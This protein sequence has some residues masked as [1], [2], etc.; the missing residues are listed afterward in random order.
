[1]HL[2]S[3]G[4]PSSSGRW[5]TDSAGLCEGFD[6]INVPAP[7]KMEKITPIRRVHRQGHTHHSLRLHNQRTVYFQRIYPV[8][9]EI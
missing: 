4:Q 8:A 5:S 1:M 2:L 6:P 7:G 3:V 9:K